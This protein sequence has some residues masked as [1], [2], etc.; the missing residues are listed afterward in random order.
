MKDFNNKVA[1]VTGAASGIG[2]A[3]AEACLARGMKTVLADINEKAL[4]ETKA[5]F[6]TKNVLTVVTDVAKADEIKVLADQAQSEFGQINLLFNNAGVDTLDDLTKPVW[7]LPTQDWELILNVNLWGVI[8]GLKTFVPIML[9][10]SNE[11]HIVNTASVAGLMSNPMMGAYMVSKHGVVTLSETLHQQL[12]AKNTKISVSVL[13]PGMVNTSI[14][15][16]T[17]AREAK[18]PNS[19]SDPNSDFVKHFEEALNQAMSAQTVADTV[20][21]AIEENRFYIFTHSNSKEAIQNR[22][23]NIAQE[24]APTVP[25]WLKKLE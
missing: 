21:D 3:L 7:E 25:E 22:F 8:N 19:E 24:A 15:K 11:A 23:K 2:R 10:Q 17:M 20:F 9:E 14:F 18:T 5:S 16:N 12:S 1:V 13:C 4:I 6:N